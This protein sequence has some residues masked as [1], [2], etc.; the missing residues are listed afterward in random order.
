MDILLGLIN[1]LAL[2][3]SL[4]AIYGVLPLAASR[5]KPLIE[6]VITGLAVG[7]IGIA[8]M[9][10]PLPFSPGIVFDT[11]SILLSISGLFF[12]GLPT[13]I[14]VV[15]TGLYRLSQGGAGA[16]TGVGVILTSAAI[17]LAW[18]YLRRKR[19][20]ETGL[21]ELYL[22]GMVVHIIMLLMMLTLPRESALSVLRNISLPVM[23]LYPLATVFVGRLFSSQLTRKILARQLADSETRYR[24]LFESAADGIFIIDQVGNCIDVNQSACRLLGYARADLL[25]RNFLELT[26]PLSLENPLLEELQVKK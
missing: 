23:A 14:G 17:G 5:K 4:W 11:R 21:L 8:V 20:Q 13:L 10:N 12:G 15:I 2:L 25:D 9:L 1:N 16:W 6:Q 26:D 7:S 18:R 22:L 19:E 24:N 3:L